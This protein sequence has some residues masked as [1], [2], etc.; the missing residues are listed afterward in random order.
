MFNCSSK[1][2]DTFHVLTGDAKKT[3]LCIPVTFNGK[4]DLMP[5]AYCT[6]AELRALSTLTKCRSDTNQRFA[7]SKQYN[8]EYISNKN[9]DILKQRL[10]NASF[11]NVCKDM[12]C[13]KY[14]KAGSE[15]CPNTI[16]DSNCYQDCKSRMSRQPLGVCNELVTGKV[17]G[18]DDTT[19]TRG[20]LCTS[21]HNM[22]DVMYPERT[23]LEMRNPNSTT[24]QARYLADLLPKTVDAKIF[25]SAEESD[26]AKSERARLRAVNNYDRMVNNLLKRF[27]VL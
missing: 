14:A 24:V 21:V 12:L 26:L 11:D 8:T 4:R 5:T 13:Y 22:S 20:R 23:E 7:R 19:N 15:Q 3:R 6:D 27:V 9:V 16:Q 1:N 25:F 2:S 18:C 17:N 10:N